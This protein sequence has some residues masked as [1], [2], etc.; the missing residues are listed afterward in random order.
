[1]TVWFDKFG[2]LHEKPQP[3]QS[4][5]GILFTVEYW[6]LKIIKGKVDL[7]NPKKF[8]SYQKIAN[9]L[10]V[11]LI[12]D[13][14]NFH[15]KPKEVGDW[16]DGDHFSHDNMTAVVAISYLLDLKYKKSGLKNIFKRSLS[17]EPKI[18]RFVCRL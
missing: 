18:A 7:K 1:M 16:H 4:E 9:D 17:L 14:G 11:Q 10:I 15:S 12:D 6:L 2:F 5:N 8:K 13:K 3:Y